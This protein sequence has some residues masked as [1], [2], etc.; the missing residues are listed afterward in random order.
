MTL[1]PKIKLATDRMDYNDYT[2]TNSGKEITLGWPSVN[3]M[4]QILSDIGLSIDRGNFLKL[5]TQMQ[6]ITPWLSSA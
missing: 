2:D 3:S 5:K 6:F 4:L 1:T